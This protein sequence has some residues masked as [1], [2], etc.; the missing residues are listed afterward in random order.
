MKIKIPDELKPWL[1]DDWDYINRQKK[2]RNL[3]RCILFFQQHFTVSP[4]THFIPISQL[5]LANLPSKVPVDT[6]LEDYIKHKS[7]NRTTTPSKYVVILLLLLAKCVPTITYI[8]CVYLLNQ[9]EKL[10]FY[11]F[12]LIHIFSFRESAIQEVMAGLKEYFN[13]TLGS[14]LLYKFERLQYADVSHEVKFAMIYCTFI[15]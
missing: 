10:F 2:V 4:N 9:V 15:R 6:I 12:S 11:F 8:L 3:K 1:V 13:V 14:S 5:Q 7:S